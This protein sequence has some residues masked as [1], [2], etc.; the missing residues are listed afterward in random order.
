MLDTLIVSGVVSCDPSNGKCK[1][2]G[3]RL[4]GMVTVSGQPAGDVVGS[5][6]LLAADMKLFYRLRRPPILHDARVHVSRSRV[7]ALRP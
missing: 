1:E 3:D 4:N 5:G 6:G 7:D 2:G